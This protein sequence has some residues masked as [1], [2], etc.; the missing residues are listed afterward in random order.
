[1]DIQVIKSVGSTLVP[2]P[3][4][5]F[6]RSLAATAKPAAAAGACGATTS[7]QC[8]ALVGA[9]HPEIKTGTALDLVQA[10]R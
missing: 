6:E 7:Q 4:S 1:M 8:A 3:L 10:M 2:C 5:H 9:P